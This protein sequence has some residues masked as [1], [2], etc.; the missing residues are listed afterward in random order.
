MHV[1]GVVPHEKV[2]SF[3][4]AADL[5]WAA[6]RN[7][8][9]SPLKAF[10]YMAMGKPGVAAGGGAGPSGAG[11]VAQR[12]GRGHRKPPE[13][14]ADAAAAHPVAPRGRAA[15]ARGL[16]LGDGRSSRS[17][18]VTAATML[19]LIRERVLPARP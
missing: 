12:H 10:E 4:A 18:S 7:E 9:G 1:T 11:G 6:Y 15:G 5:L 3:L 14:L 2:P 17:W 13:E 19:T 16:R 8:Y